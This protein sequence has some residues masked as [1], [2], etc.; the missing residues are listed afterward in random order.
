MDVKLEFTPGETENSKSSAKKARKFNIIGIFSGIICI[1]ICLI[2]FI[3]IFIVFYLSVN[4]AQ[5]S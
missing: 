5:N 1:F 4:K 2:L 3:L